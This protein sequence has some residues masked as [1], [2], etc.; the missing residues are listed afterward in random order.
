MEMLQIEAKKRS[1]LGTRATKKLRGEGQ[2]PCVLYGQGEECVSLVLSKLDVQTFFRQRGRIMHLNVE[3][4]EERA[5]L[6]DIQYDSMGNNIIH[7]DLLRIRLDQVISIRVPVS[8][9]GVAK[10]VEEGG[11]MQI[12]RNDIQVK[13]LPTQIP[14]AID[15]N[16]AELGLQEALHLKDVHFPEGVELDEEP[17]YTVVSIVSKTV[18]PEPETDEEGEELGEG[19]E[20][21]G[22]EEDDASKDGSASKDDDARSK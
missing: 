10:G 16:V 12:L 2:L 4:V 17:E 7:L 8:I 3:G 18:E 21:E 9:I 22:G 11:I 6:R 1:D 19:E 14:Q 20:A 13:C 5:I 15:V